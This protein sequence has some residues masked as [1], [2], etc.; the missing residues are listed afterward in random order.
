M[1]NN[2]SQRKQHDETDD[3]YNNTPNKF[4]LDNKTV[5]VLPLVMGIICVPAT[6]TRCI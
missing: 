6:I 1:T 4:F 2:P 3:D 5:N